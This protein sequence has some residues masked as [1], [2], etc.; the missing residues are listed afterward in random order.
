MTGLK[1]DALE[2][3]KYYANSTKADIITAWIIRD[4]KIDKGKPRLPWIFAMHAYIIN[5][6]VSALIRRSLHDRYGLYSKRFTMMADMYFIKTACKDGTTKICRA[7]FLSGEFGN[8]GVSSVDKV[9]GYCDYFRV[10]FETERFKSVQILLFIA[11]LIW[12][13][14]I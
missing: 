11:K 7:P 12:R 4:G 10:Q 2:Q 14:S 9:T 8:S 6:S 13:S 3:F 5:H 1:P